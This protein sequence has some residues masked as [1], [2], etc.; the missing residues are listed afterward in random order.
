[1]GD[2]GLGCHERLVKLHVIRVYLYG[3]IQIAS[4][5]CS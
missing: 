1:M 3:A 5:N 2:F 4:T